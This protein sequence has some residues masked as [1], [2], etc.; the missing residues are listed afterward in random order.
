MLSESLPPSA[1]ADNNYTVSGISYDT[2]QYLVVVTGQSKNGS[3][4][5]EFSST[6]SKR[7]IDSSGDYGPWQKLEG[8]GG[9]AE[10][11]ALP[12]FSNTRTSKPASAAFDGYVRYFDE[13]GSHPLE[14]GMFEFSITA[15]GE[16]SESAPLP[17]S[18]RLQ[19]PQE[20]SPS[21]P[22]T[23]LIART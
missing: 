5:L 23:S 22:S 18:Y 21:A 8:T 6:V 3:N 19:T 14:D 20:H 17:S 7:T 16:N 15:V 10:D 12:V 11:A 4:T 2:A 13:T 9:L 1:T